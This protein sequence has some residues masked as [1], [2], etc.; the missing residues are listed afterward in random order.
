[1]GVRAR[2]HA[3]EPA[4]LGAAGGGPAAAA[5]EAGGGQEGDAGADGGGSG[6]GGPACAGGAA[7]ERF[8]PHRM[9]LGRGRRRDRQLG[10][11]F[12]KVA[13]WFDG[14]DGPAAGAARGRPERPDCTLAWAYM[15]YM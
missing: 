9:L 1:G 6:G 7:G 12:R 10:R 3:D 8:G 15:T 4:D 2:A 5:V 11:D 13:L 14:A